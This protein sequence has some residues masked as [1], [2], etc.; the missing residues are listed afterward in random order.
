MR[1]SV[2]VTGAR[3]S[4]GRGRASNWLV[5]RG[6]RPSTAPA[7]KPSIEQADGICR[8]RQA[9]GFG[10]VKSRAENPPGPVSRPPF[11][12]SRD[13]PLR[14]V[15]LTVLPALRD[16]EELMRERGLA[17]DHSTIERWV[18]RYALELHKRLRRELRRP[19]RSWRVDET[20]IRVAGAWTYLYR[21]VDSISCC[22]RSVMWLQPSTS[23][24]WHCGERGRSDPAS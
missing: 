21:A 10:R 13:R 3:S 17:V 14:S 15:V 23:C 5:R 20:C 2:R 8:K 4:P 22:R 16:L 7:A 11:R 24:K 9:A 19:N 1:T 12:G 18:L 6:T